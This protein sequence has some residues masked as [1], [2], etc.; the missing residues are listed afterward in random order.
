MSNRPAYNN[1]SLTGGFYIYHSKNRYL[2]TFLSGRTS[3]PSY[4]LHRVGLSFRWSFCVPSVSRCDKVKRHQDTHL[5]YILAGGFSCGYEKGADMWCNYLTGID[6]SPC[7]GW[8]RKRHV[9]FHW[10]NNKNVCYLYCI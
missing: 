6:R 8:F 5:P 3:R 1:R 9:A 2:C 10:K 7:R 4:I